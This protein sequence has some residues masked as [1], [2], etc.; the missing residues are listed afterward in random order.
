[1][2]DELLKLDN[3]LCFSLYSTSLAME[4]LYRK[5]LKDL[6]VTYPQYLVLL[7]LWDQ[8][9]MTV[10]ELGK[11]LFLDSG[12]LT[13]LLKRLEKE[14]LVIRE[15]SSEDERRVMITLTPEGKK[16]KEKAYAV[17]KQILDCSCLGRAELMKIKNELNDLREKITLNV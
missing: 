2:K 1:M 5:L 11:L 9:E 12:T 13:P 17:P 10:S 8:K 3:Q 14:G 6:G 16:L 4:K 7:C 15:R